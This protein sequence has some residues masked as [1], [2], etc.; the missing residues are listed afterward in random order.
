ML[1]RPARAFQ[2]VLVFRAEKERHGEQVGLADCWKVHEF[3]L[4]SILKIR[5]LALA[6]RPLAKSSE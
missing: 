1:G 4:K 2:Q 6:L 5:L 3:T